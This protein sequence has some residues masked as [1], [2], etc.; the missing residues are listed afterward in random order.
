[1]KAA[2]MFFNFGHLSIAMREIF[3]SHTPEF[4]RWTIAQPCALRNSAEWASPEW[5]DRELRALRVYSEAVAEGRILDGICVEREANF[6]ETSAQGFVAA[7]VLAAYGGADFAHCQCRYCPANA[8][9]P[10]ELDSLAGCYGWFELSALSDEL[11]SRVEQAAKKLASDETWARAFL[12]TRPRWYGLWVSS[13][14]TAQQ[15]E[16]HHQLAL[17]LSADDEHFRAAFEDWMKAV[18]A[19]KDAQLP[20][21]VRLYPAGQIQDR[22]WTVAAHCPQCMAERA[23]RSRSCAVCGL[24]ACA[25][26]PKRRHLRGT[27]PFR[28]LREFMNEEKLSRFTARYLAR[29]K[30]L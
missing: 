22:R 13:P 24:Q 8:V 25:L 26:P 29:D 7:D 19:A 11:H 10:K 5:A 3:E 27:R 2:L 9:R 6:S 20:L 14:L 4:V 30:K 16:L 17:T 1:M 21:H 18:A 23:E 12:P 28:P 15:L